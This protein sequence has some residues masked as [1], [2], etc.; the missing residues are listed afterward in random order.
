M[1]KTII[2]LLVLFAVAGVLAADGHHGEDE[3][4]H[5]RYSFTDERMAIMDGY[6]DLVPSELT[7][8]QRAQ[9]AGDLSIPLQK[10]W[11]IARSS[12]AS[13]VLP[14]AGQ[15]MNGDSLSGALFLTG[16]LVIAAGT[17][18]G[19]YFLLPEELQVGQ[20]DYA[21]S[22]KT[23]ISDAWTA[24][25]TDITTAESWPLAAVISAGMILDHALSHFSARHAGRL[26]FERIESGDK[27]F[28][29]R[30]ELL[31]GPGGFGFGMSFGY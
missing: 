21:N 19:A 20:L 8:G 11:Y 3:G 5:D 13:A 22:T 26:A 17:L 14:G 24:A 2:L 9:I 28:R 15:F 23:E 6:A 1:R 30:P 25:F 10:E 16:D 18:I 29:P 12:F 7:F 27:T 31:M 4:H